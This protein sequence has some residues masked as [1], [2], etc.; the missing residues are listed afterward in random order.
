LEYYKDHLKLKLLLQ[1]LFLPHPMMV[2]KVLLHLQIKMLDQTLFRQLVVS[3][4]VHTLNC[5]IQLFLIEKLLK[6]WDLQIMKMLLLQKMQ[7]H[8]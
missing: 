5:S 7:H 4:I 6:Y 2:Q 3:F 1:F 8:N